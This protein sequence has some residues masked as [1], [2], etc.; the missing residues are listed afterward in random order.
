MKSYNQPIVP[1]LYFE[2][3]R[4]DAELTKN[5]NCYSPELPPELLSLCLATYANWGDLAKLA[6]V[7]KS[8]SNV[9]MDTA[10]QSLSS[11]WE[12]AT[13]LFEGDCDLV[14]SPERAVRILKELS[15]V[16]IDEST[17]KPLTAQENKNSAKISSEDA[18]YQVCAMKKIAK[19][20]LEG[21]GV[22]Q[23]SNVAVAWMEAAFLVGND[24]ESAH[25]L[26]VMYEYGRHG[27][28]IDV[29]AAAEW[30]ER[31]ATE[32]NVESMVELGLCYELGCGV[33][34]SDELALDWYTKAAHL[35]HPTA[36]FSVGEIFEE[37]RGVPQSDE[38]ACLWYYRAALV[39]CDDSK[40]ALR[41]LY[42]I[43]R[44]V[45]PGVNSILS[46]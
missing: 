5:D 12:L 13:A 23:D 31:G 45:V 20:Y 21:E 29:V 8:W 42:D 18:K 30:F 35:G 27:I 46:V 14:T 34:Q 17:G 25:D 15:H 38:E 26:A 16:T 32:G 4:S 3:H 37:A 2:T 1:T 19:C 11:R 39:G 7:Q 36:K 40:V 10:N 44:I 24:A 9:V 43:A 22:P 41:R 33:E 6:C 28:E